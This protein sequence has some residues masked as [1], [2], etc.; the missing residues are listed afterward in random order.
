MWDQAEKALAET[1]DKFGQV[2]DFKI[3]VI[4]TSAC[5]RPY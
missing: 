1:L 2:A 5:V 4:V 3:P